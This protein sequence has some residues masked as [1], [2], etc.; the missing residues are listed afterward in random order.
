MKVL[1]HVYQCYQK[2]SVPFY[3]LIIIFIYIGI[4]QIV[5]IVLAFQT[6]RVRVPALNDSKQVAALIYISSISFLSIILITLG[7]GEF[8]N[9]RVSLFNTAIFITASTFVILTFLPKVCV[10]SRNNYLPVWFYFSHVMHF[11]GRSNY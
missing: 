7:L 5:G 8:L 10:M 11:N 4:L 3:W 9:T 2:S 6:R 1:N